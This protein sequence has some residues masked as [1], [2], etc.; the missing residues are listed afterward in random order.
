MLYISHPY[1]TYI[2]IAQFEKLSILV[3]MKDPLDM[4]QN[5]NYFDWN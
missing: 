2:S 5:W 1:S 4:D 3:I